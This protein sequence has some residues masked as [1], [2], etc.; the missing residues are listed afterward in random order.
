[1]LVTYNAHGIEGIDQDWVT[2]V[3]RYS[4]IINGDAL[5]PSEKK[6]LIQLFIDYKREDMNPL[7]AMKKA[8]LLFDNIRS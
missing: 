6:K 5:P 7:N 8:I 4:S 3:A 1:M 2:E